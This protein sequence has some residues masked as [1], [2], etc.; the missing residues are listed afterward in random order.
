MIAK[1]LTFFLADDVWAYPRSSRVRPF[2]AA[3]EVDE[4]LGGP[5]SRIVRRISAPA[6]VLVGRGESAPP[7]EAAADEARKQE[8]PRAALFT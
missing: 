7:L 4:G 3:V 1:A 5:L 2:V 8:L 6:G